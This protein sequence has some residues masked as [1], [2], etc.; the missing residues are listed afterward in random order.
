MSA[1]AITPKLYKSLQGLVHFSSPYLSR[2]DI[3]DLLADLIVQ[4]AGR[5]TAGFIFDVLPQVDKMFDFVA[6]AAAELQQPSVETAEPGPGGLHEIIEWIAGMLNPVCIYRAS[7]LVGAESQAFSLLIA[8]P[9]TANK[10]LSDYS[11]VINTVCLQAREINY[12]LCKIGQLRKYVEV[13][14][15]FHIS[16]CTAEHL[17]YYN[18]REPLPDCSHV[19]VE[20]VKECA[21]ARFTTGYCRGRAFA[22]GARYYLEH[23][24]YEMVPFML[25]QAIELTLLHAVIAISRVGIHDHS[26][27]NLLKHCGRFAPPITKLFPGDEKT[28]TRLIAFLEASYLDARYS[29]HYEVVE[30]QLTTLCHWAD[31]LL[32][33]TQAIVCELINGFDPVQQHGVIQTSEL[34]KPEAIT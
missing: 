17:L 31:V 27:S 1:P 28:E 4:Q 33:A 3:R 9:T 7:P 32:P 10:R 23:G 16:A 21:M 24:Q 18:G 30:E 8:M 5:G 26:I 2:E 29:D 15:I 22:D 6:A 34:P 11:S 20:S 12:T 13:G 25:H 14:S 19:A